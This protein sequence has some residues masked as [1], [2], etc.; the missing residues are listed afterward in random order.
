MQVANNLT[1]NI[2][3]EVYCLEPIFLEAVGAGAN[4]EW[5]VSPDFNV[6]IEDIN[7][8]STIA[9][10]SAYGTYIF[11][12][13]ICGDEFSTS[14]N[15]GSITPNLSSESNTYSCLESF[16]LEAQVQGDPGYWESEGPYLVNIDNPTSLNPT[17]TVNGYGTYI[18]TY[19]GCGTSNTIEINM[20]AIDPSASGPEEI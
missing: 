15:V 18:F 13:T 9:N 7:A 6:D 5:S 4:G 2:P 10:V 20:T 17:V 16:S 19:Y 3:D 14:V 1:F 8:S 12:Y 11:T